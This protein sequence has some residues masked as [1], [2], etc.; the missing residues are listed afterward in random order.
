M[1]GD[2]TR[3]FAAGPSM[4]RAPSRVVREARSR[5]LPYAQH[6]GGAAERGAAACAQ[7]R[8]RRSSPACGGGGPRVSVVEGGA[9]RTGASGRPL[10]SRKRA[11]PPPRLRRRGGPGLQ[12][13]LE[14]SLPRVGLRAVPKAKSLQWSDFRR[15]GH[16]SYARMARAAR[17]ERSELSKPGWGDSPHARCPQP[18]FVHLPNPQALRA[19]QPHFKKLMP[20]ALRPLIFSSSPR[21]ARSRRTVCGGSWGSRES[22]RGGPMREPRRM[23]QFHRPPRGVC[24]NP[25]QRVGGTKV[26]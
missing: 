24:L 15:E 16:E 6:G 22:S 8:S 14:L 25:P 23:A 7:A 5:V 9:P 20:G 3:R 2:V 17:L 1:Q 10:P 19:S 26:P 18:T 12:L 13:R 21:A 4:R 11:P